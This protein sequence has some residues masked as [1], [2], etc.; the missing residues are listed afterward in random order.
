MS[1]F[2]KKIYIYKYIQ[3]VYKYIIKVNTEI[4]TFFVIAFVSKIS[5]LQKKIQNIFTRNFSI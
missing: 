1:T 3:V 2:R 5:K 4:N